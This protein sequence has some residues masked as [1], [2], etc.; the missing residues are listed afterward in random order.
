MRWLF[1]NFILQKWMFSNIVLFF[2]Y[3]IYVFASCISLSLFLYNILKYK[4]DIRYYEMIIFELHPPE[5]N[6]FQYCCPFFPIYYLC[7]CFLYFS[8]PI[9]LSVSVSLSVCLSVCLSFCL[10]VSL[11]LSLSV[12]LSFSQVMENL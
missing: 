6:D 11:S 9:S 10:S 1:L 8:V 2:Q 12:S 5:M 3:I 4:E 7:I